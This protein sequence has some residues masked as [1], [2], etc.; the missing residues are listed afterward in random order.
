MDPL[1]ERLADAGRSWRRRQPPPRAVEDLLPPQVRSTRARSWRLVG[2]LLA[3]VLV[4]ALGAVIATLRLPGFLEGQVGASPA[5]SGS[6]PSASPSQAASPGSGEVIDSA[7]AWGSIEWS[8]DGATLAAAAN[9]QASFQGDIRLYDRTGHRIRALPGFQSAWVDAGHLITLTADPSGQ[10]WSAWLR[11][12][13]GSQSTRVAGTVDL[14]DDGRGSVALVSYSSGAEPAFQVWTAGRLS[15]S[16]PGRPVAWSAD[17]RLLAVFRVDA[18][19]ADA[20]GGRT[21]AWLEVV[22]ATDL[23]VLHDFAAPQFDS[24]SRALFDP[25]GRMVATDAGIFDLSNG[26]VADLPANSSAV[27]WLP[28]GR[29]VVSSPDGLSVRTWD[30][31]TATASSPLPAGT[32][33]ATADGDVVTV[34]D[35]SASGLVELRAGGAVSPDGMVRAW[36]PAATG[37]GDTPLHLGPSLGIRG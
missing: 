16:H 15:A 31:A 9:D 30:P 32:Q 5:P 17:G 34:P 19:P 36:A 37:T 29:L 1:E 13:D 14:V 26:S 22:D 7:W 10:G 24:R 6:A 2:G 35:P 18:G 8:P 4:L 21:L 28:D 25:S 12:L 23:R 20:A 11:S 27:A 3:A 33:L